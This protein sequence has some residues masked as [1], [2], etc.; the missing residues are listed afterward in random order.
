MHNVTDPGVHECVSCYASLQNVRAEVTTDLKNFQGRGGQGEGGEGGGGGEG[1]AKKPAR[2]EP[3][4]A[5]V[6][7]GRFHGKWFQS[8]WLI[9]VFRL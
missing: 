3:G 5:A 4:P 7:T 8:A 6:A 2:I 1:A 9:K